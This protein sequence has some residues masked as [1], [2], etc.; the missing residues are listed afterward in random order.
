MTAL[1]RRAAATLTGTALLAAGLAAASTAPTQAAVPASAATASALA[2][3]EGQLG[4][5]DLLGTAAS[6]NVATTLD[7]GIGLVRTGADADLLTRVR[8][9]IDARLAATV[10]TSGDLTTSGVTA[11]A[12]QFYA[13]AGQ[14]PAALPGETLVQR[15]EA[16]VDG[17][18]QLI[19]RYND[20]TTGDPV[21]YPDSFNQPSAV[22]A[23]AKG[24]SAEAPAAIARLIDSQCADG[25]FGL[26]PF[27]DPSKPAV[28][29][30][31]VDTTAASIQA[32]KE[33][34]GVTGADDDIADATAWLLSQQAADGS[35]KTAFT[36]PNTNSTGLAAVALD[37]VGQ[38]AAA[39][40]AAAWVRRHQLTGFTCDQALS[41]ETGAI[42]YTDEA[43]ASDLTGGLGSRS[44]I[45]LATAQAFP[46]LTIAPA[47]GRTLSLSAPRFVKA[48]S[49]VALAVDGLAPG[50]R[51]CAAVAGRSAAVVG[52]QAPTARI[53]V[54]AGTRSYTAVVK[55]PGVTRYATVTALA[56]KTLRLLVRSATV[57]RGG[58]Q[59]VRVT[60]LVPGERVVA[61]YGTTVVGTGVANASGYARFTF[62]VG[63]SA[64]AKSVVARGQFDTRRGSVGFRVR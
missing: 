63:R 18:G 5:D 21:D 40:K 19:G 8:G 64:G 17:T 53:A 42:T 6:P 49:T 30:S 24:G 14:T 54:P 29:A 20:F 1:V 28:C 47:S 33:A 48:G 12:A 31:E 22:V 4:D 11:K 25:G 3:L 55:V 61:R 34:P 9:G 43:L 7:L 62:A 38:D 2:W 15:V 26:D 45:T 60:G 37:L 44:E 16:V 27:T 10:K 59:T 51:G 35:F 36:A 41:A 39:A 58:T 32:L 23:L 57:T 13:L 56:P 46:A 50:E 52:V